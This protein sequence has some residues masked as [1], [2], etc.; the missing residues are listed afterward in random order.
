MKHVHK[1]IGNP[2][3]HHEEEKEEPPDNWDKRE[4]LEEE[5]KREHKEWHQ[6]IHAQSFF[7]RD[8]PI[9]SPDHNRYPD[10]TRDK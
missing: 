2:H 9:V 10:G 7:N 4:N 8:R 3:P 5:H 1:W 6:H